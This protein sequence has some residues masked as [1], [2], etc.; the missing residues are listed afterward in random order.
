MQFLLDLGLFK[1][2]I[3]LSRSKMYSKLILSGKITRKWILLYGRNQES[4]PGP[5]IKVQSTAQ[6]TNLDDP[7]GTYEGIDLRRPLM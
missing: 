2:D 1:L 7:E 4:Y 5:T 3:I 6:I